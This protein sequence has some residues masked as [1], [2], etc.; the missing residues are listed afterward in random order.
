[1]SSQNLK[2][3]TIRETYPIRGQ[4]RI[5]R[6]SKS[7][8]EVVVCH[9]EVHGNLGRGECVPY[10]HYNETLDSVCAQ[11]EQLAATADFDHFEDQIASLPAGAARNALD[12][13]FWDWK[14][15]SSGKR[16]ETLIAC[17]PPR[18]IDTALTISLDTPENMA[19]A[20]RAASKRNLIKVKLGGSQDAAC[21]HAVVANAPQSMIIIDANEAWTP[22]VFHDLMREAAH[23]NIALIEQPLPADQDDF[24]RTVP[25]PV[26]ICADES[27][28]TSD[29]LESLLGKYDF[30][31]IK[32]DKTGGLT[33]AL[34][35]RDKAKEMGFGI[36]VGCMVGSS[37]AMA[38]A[39]LLAQGADFVDLDGPLLLTYDR[40]PALHYFGSTV[41][42]PEP[43]LWG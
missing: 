17:P 37:L 41:S 24:L 38:P 13:A 3:T 27:V 30:V 36:M 35:M 18:P 31:N 26:P 43:I 21:M 16:I 15:K 6:G 23:L 7:E 9:I 28:H 33:E 25:H 19:S 14:A 22:E 40:H 11:I 4:F 1:M 34:K 12:C 39:V 5:S 29:D 10:R 20:A 42:P 8:A 2:I 32:L